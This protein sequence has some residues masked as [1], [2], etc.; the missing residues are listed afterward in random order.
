MLKVLDGAGAGEL[1]DVGGDPQQHPPDAIEVDHDVAAVGMIGVRAQVDHR[2]VLADF[3]L[4]KPAGAVAH[5]GRRVR[6]L[7]RDL[8]QLLADAE[9]PSRV[10]ERTVTDEPGTDEGWRDAER[11]WGGA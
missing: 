8:D 6:V 2:R 4:L 7:R 9:Q 1:V 10:E 11:F 3:E 5:V